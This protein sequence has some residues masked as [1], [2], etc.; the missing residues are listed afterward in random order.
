MVLIAKLNIL[1]D[2]MYNELKKTLA[3]GMHEGIIFDFDLYEIS[4]R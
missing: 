1:N 3:L 2:K 4:V